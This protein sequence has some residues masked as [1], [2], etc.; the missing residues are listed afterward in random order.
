M[1]QSHLT[2][3][4]G[5]MLDAGFLPE[6]L[7]VDAQLVNLVGELTLR[8][9]GVLV[10]GVLKSSIEPDKVFDGSVEVVTFIP[11]S[12]AAGPGYASVDA[13]V[14][15]PAA[16]LGVGAGARASAGQYELSGRLTT[17]FRDRDLAGKVAGK[18]PDVAGTVGPA[19]NSA[20]HAVGASVGSAAASAGG[21]IRS[22]A[23]RA[24][25]GV[26]AG[27]RKAGDFVGPVAGK[28]GS[29]LGSFA[30]TGLS[31]AG[32]AISVGKAKV[33]GGAEYAPSVAPGM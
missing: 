15:V 25:Q 8:R 24:A 5:Y 16:R 33:G 7:G 28:A 21:A 12:K 10:N 23:E 13:G 14:R 32:N 26:S 30:R 4:G 3:K 19:L 11:F 2:L 22:A 6:Q 20:G 1:A 27:V 18:L 17:P 29:T 9:E 31:F